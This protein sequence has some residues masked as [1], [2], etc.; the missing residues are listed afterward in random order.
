MMHIVIYVIHD[1]LCKLLLCNHI[2]RTH[3]V[4]LEIWK[5]LLWF[6][7]IGRLNKYNPRVVILSNLLHLFVIFCH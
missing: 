5:F 2:T 3:T 4:F 1:I 7:W 6:F